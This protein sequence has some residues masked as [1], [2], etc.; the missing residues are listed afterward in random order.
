MKFGDIV[1]IRKDCYRFVERELQDA[2]LKVVSMGRT[3]ASVTALNTGY[4]GQVRLEWLEPCEKQKSKSF[5]AILIDAHN[6]EVK[7]V[8]M[9]SVFITP[10]VEMYLMTKLFGRATVR[11]N[12]KLYT[13]HMVNGAL[14]DLPRFNTPIWGGSVCGN[15]LLNKLDYSE[16]TEDEFNKIKDTVTFNVNVARRLVWA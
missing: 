1:Q 4:I 11:I 3:L 8:P 16:I 10:M 13:Y 6:Q 2:Q 12:E 5:Q 14:R 7:I 15:L 9:E